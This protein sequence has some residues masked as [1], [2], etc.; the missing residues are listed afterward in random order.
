MDHELGGDFQVHK[1]KRKIDSC[2]TEEQRLT[3]CRSK[4]NP[5][6]KKVLEL[7]Q[8][9]RS[10]DQC[11]DYAYYAFSQIFQVIP[12]GHCLLAHFLLV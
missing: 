6:K 4:N 9:Y 12:E 5:I 11:Q 7:K 8:K 2:Q 3:G 1:I 10:P